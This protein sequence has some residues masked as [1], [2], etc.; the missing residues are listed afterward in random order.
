MKIPKNEIL[1]ISYY[2]NGSRFFILTEDAAKHS[3]VLYE[4]AEDG[5]KKLGRA[6][7]PAELEEKFGVHERLAG[8]VKD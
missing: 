6:S 8:E 3:F 1:R 2:A 7:S 5:P 4:T